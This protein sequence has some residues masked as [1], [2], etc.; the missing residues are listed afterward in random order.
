VRLVQ[1]D[2]LMYS[3][4]LQQLSPVELLTEQDTFDFYVLAGW[5]NFAPKLSKRLFEQTNQI[6]SNLKDR[7]CI[8]YINMDFQEGWEEEVEP[9][10][11][12]SKK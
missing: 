8:S 2:S 7:L 5:A 11:S 12:V 9:S 1:E 4:I 3:F 6:K 10:K